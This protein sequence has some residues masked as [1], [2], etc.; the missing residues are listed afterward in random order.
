MIVELSF[1]SKLLFLQSHYQFFTLV[2]KITNFP[3]LLLLC[4]CQLS[5]FVFFDL[6]DSF[7]IADLGLDFLLLFSQLLRLIGDH[8]FF[9]SQSLILLRNLHYLRG[10]GL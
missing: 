10:L 7:V 3:L 1:F 8:P 4:A 5:D 6:D 9:S 2:F